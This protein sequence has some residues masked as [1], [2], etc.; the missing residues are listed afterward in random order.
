MPLVLNLKVKAYP[1]VCYV[2]YHLNRRDAS[3]ACTHTGLITQL[4]THYSTIRNL[5]GI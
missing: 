3:H 5:G 4:H 1:I 2:L